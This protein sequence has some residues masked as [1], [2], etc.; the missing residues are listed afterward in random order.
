MFGFIGMATGLK[1]IF[2]FAL[3]DRVIKWSGGTW[4]VPPEVSSCR[5]EPDWEYEQDA[6]L[7]A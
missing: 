7:L 2:Q 6:V 3:P 4:T 1:M 5:L